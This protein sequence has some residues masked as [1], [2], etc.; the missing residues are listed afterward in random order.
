MTL[1]LKSR[2]ISLGAVSAFVCTVFIG[3]AIADEPA[4]QKEFDQAV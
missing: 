2:L 4:S 3:M 1:K